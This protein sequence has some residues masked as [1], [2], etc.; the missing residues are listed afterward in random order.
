MNE[1]VRTL[2]ERASEIRRHIK[3]H[4][5]EAEGLVLDLQKS[6][7]ERERRQR[8]LAEVEQ[9]IAALKPGGVVQNHEQDQRAKNRVFSSIGDVLVGQAPMHGDFGTVEAAPATRPGWQQRVLD[10]KA[11]LVGRITRLRAFIA[12]DGFALAHDEH[13][14]LTKQLA[15]MSAYSD[16]LGARIAAFSATDAQP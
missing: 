1:A 16:I 8:T 12:S 15:M 11:G 9:G 2:E 13:V 10:E 6:N 5:E 3:Q 7:D 14:R 4:Q